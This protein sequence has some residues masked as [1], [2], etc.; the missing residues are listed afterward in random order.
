MCAHIE[1]ARPCVYALS[2]LPSSPGAKQT[3]GPL[4]LTLRAQQ[5]S[6][7]GQSFIAAGGRDGCVYMFV[8]VFEEL[9]NYRWL[10]STVWDIQGEVRVSDLFEETALKE[11]HSPLTLIC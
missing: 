4:Y 10:Q 9:R 7:E 5:G 6:S 11:M 2:F 8:C 3:V 1:C